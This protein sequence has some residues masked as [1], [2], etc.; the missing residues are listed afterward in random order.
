MELEIEQICE[1]DDVFNYQCNLLDNGLLYINFVD[2][3]SEG[4]GNRIVRSW[5]SML[6]HFYAAKKLSTL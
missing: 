4:D 3:L 6:L 2:A 5:K 1:P